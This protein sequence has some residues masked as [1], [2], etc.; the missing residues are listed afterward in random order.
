MNKNKKITKDIQRCS[1]ICRLRQAEK[2]MLPPI[3]IFTSSELDIIKL[4]CRQNDFTMISCAIL[5]KLS[6]I[7]YGKLIHR[8]YENTVNHV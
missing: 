7:S 2:Q 1:R 5:K 6:K 3:A 4:D 8:R